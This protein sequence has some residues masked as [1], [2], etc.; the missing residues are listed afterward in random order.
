M[1]GSGLDEVRRQLSDVSDPVALLVGLFANAPVGLQIYRADGHCLISNQ[2]FRDIFGS[3]PPPEYNLFNDNLLE[4]NGT[5]ALIRRAFAGEAVTTPP[6]WYDP[7]EL[8]G[9]KVVGGRRC[10]VSCTTFPLFDPSG[11]I[12]HVALAFKDV[13]AELQS[14]EQAEA[15]RDRVAESQAR[16]RAFLDN[17]PVV[18]FLKDLQGR[19]LEISRECARVLGR[20][21]VQVI[22]KTS[23]E[24]FE[25][26]NSSLAEERD[27]RALRER[28]PIEALEEMKEPD[29]LHTFLV[30]RF[31]IFGANGEATGTGGVAVDVTARQ[32]AEEQ[33]RRSERQFAAVF[34]ALPMAALLSRMSDRRFID[35]NDAWQRLTGFSREEMMGRTSV[36]LGLWV[37]LSRRDELFRILEAQSF[38]RDF[39]ATLRQKQ[40]ELREVLLSVERIAIAG[41]P[42]L[43]LLAHDVTELRRLE[44]EL[45]HSQKMEAVGRLAGGIAHDFNNILTAIGGADALLLD[46]LLK[47]DPLRP[48]A[49][50][51]QRS[52]ARAAGLT[53]QLL[54][55]TRKQQLEPV[56]VD[57]NDVVRATVDMLQ[58][59]IGE[60]IELR[61]ELTARGRVKADAGSLEQVLLNLAVNARDAMPAGGALSLRTADARGPDG[62]LPE[63]AWVLIGVRDAGVGMDASTRARLFEP[64][65]TTK[66]QGKGTGLGLSTVYGIVKQCGGHIFV[67]SEPGRGSDFRVYLPR[68]EAPRPAVA[69]HQPAALPGGAETVLLVEDDDAVRD[70]TRFVLAQLGY[71]VLEAS[72]GPEALEVAGRFA[73]PIDLLL[74]DVVMPRMNGVEVAQRLTAA[75]PGIKVLHISGYP[76]DFIER[77]GVPGGR[78]PLLN[79][80]FDRLG[81]ATMV[82]R[83]L[84]SHD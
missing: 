30:S 71:R 61:T 76:G 78:A 22:G 49:E 82:R 3:E 63:G 67:D 44:R 26:P 37:D 65:F 18:V 60:D 25:L 62:L 31:P 79:K 66:E 36:E 45:R 55:F 40:G 69:P 35:I 77:A 46:G 59:M 23:R 15:E 14:R 12:G 74:S 11:R 72:D 39:A 54:T 21:P 10:A 8:S 4:R 33:L 57:P 19:H 28:T 64:F 20:D 2:T 52:T 47:A 1:S 6:V 43:L 56:V 41:E 80:P 24:L 83:T 70:Y 29:G 13:T 51:I 81:L 48:Y 7:R 27:R 68:H 16:L 84:D 73:E 75:R 17:A 58:R 5:L 38:V 42:C 34:Q 50:Q 9:M 32:H 53:R